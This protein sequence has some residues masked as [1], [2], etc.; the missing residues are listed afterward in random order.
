M[1]FSTLT[2]RAA[3]GTVLMAISDLFSDEDDAIWLAS[4]LADEP[5][6]AA[7]IAGVDEHAVLLRACQMLTDRMTSDDRQL[8]SVVLAPLTTDLLLNVPSALAPHVCNA[9]SMQTIEYT[10]KSATT[11]RGAAADILAETADLE[12]ANATYMRRLLEQLRHPD[13]P[14]RTVVQWA[15]A[16]LPDD[17]TEEDRA[18]IGILLAL[19]EPRA[20]DEQLLLARH[21]IMLT[22]LARHVDEHRVRDLRLR[23]LGGGDERRWREFAARYAELVFKY[24][25]FP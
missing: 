18:I 13:V 22:K 17:M 12:G 25:S 1:A 16:A 6:P 3:V 9:A 14:T 5:D 19:F 2:D 4:I 20:H 23:I 21:D 7:H 8:L 24:R 11:L 15:C 10:C